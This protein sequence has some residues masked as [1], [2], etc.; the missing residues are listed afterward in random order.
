MK[1]FFVAML[2]ALLTGDA[3]ASCEMVHNNQELCVT[4]I[5]HSYHAVTSW[6]GHVSRYEITMP[7]SDPA[8]DL[9]VY[10]VPIAAL[11]PRE[12]SAEKRGDFMIEV[13]KTALQGGEVI[14]GDFHWR[15]RREGALLS[16]VAFRN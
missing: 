7:A 10:L 8:A 16:V 9:T 14:A 4:Q 12:F 3:A 1:F 6:R 11:L 5:G 15:A 13:L 2:L